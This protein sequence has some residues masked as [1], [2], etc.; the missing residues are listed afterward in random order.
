MIKHEWVLLK[1]GI[2]CYEVSKTQNLCVISFRKNCKNPHSLITEV[3]AAILKR[4]G[5]QDLLEKQIF[6]L[7]LQNDPFLLPEVRFYLQQPQTETSCCRV[8]LRTFLN[9]LLHNVF[10]HPPRFVHITTRAMVCTV[11]ASSP[12]PVLSFTSASTI[13]RETVSLDLAAREPIISTPMKW[14]FFKDSVRRL[15]ETSVRST[16]TNSSSWNNRRKEPLLHLVKKKDSFFSFKNQFC[17]D[18]HNSRSHLLFFGG[19]EIQ[20]KS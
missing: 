12:L 7:L 14:R 18:S 5:L 2:L 17:N 3:N 8:Q 10:E 16:E 1:K 20:D 4:H 13:C 15:L 6:Q 11:P 19:N 9:K